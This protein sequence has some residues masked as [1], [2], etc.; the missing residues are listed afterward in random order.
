[1]FV[2]HAQTWAF[3]LTFSCF[4]GKI[5][6]KCNIFVK[7][8]NETEHVSKR[9][10]AMKKNFLVAL[11]LAGALCLSAPGME[12]DAAW[13]ITSSGRQYTLNDGQGYATGWKKIGNYWYYFNKEGYAQTGWHTI[14]KK[15]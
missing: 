5:L 2:E 11:S 3:Y 15:L 12:A 7:K 1:M 10:L 14:K 8:H 13:K 4:Y 6:Y 9:S